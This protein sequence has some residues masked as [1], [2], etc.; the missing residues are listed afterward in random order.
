MKNR[1]TIFPATLLA[2]A[3]F[4][5]LPI[6]NLPPDGSYLNRNTAEGDD[7]LFSLTTGGGNGTAVTGAAVKVS[8][9]GQLYDP[10]RSEKVR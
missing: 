4:A 3:C 5:L 1:N 7:A 9:S 2:L 10:D 6:A 8:A